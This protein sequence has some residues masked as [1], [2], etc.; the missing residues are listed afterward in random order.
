MELNVGVPCIVLLSG[1]RARFKA[2]IKYV[3]HLA[4]VSRPDLIEGRTMS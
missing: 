1:K 2:A 3:G 4:N